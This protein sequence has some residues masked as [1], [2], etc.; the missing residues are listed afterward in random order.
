MTT[1]LFP[2]VVPDYDHLQRI[3][4]VV[5]CAYCNY[6]QKAV[7]V[8]ECPK[9]FKCELCQVIN[10]QFPISHNKNQSNVTTNH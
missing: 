2:T 8:E 6:Q 10:N 3:N 1:D 9:A 5:A 4:S 7:F